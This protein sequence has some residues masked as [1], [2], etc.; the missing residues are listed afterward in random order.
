MAAMLSTVVFSVAAT[1]AP[2]G[3]LH[4]NGVENISVTRLSPSNITGLLNMNSASHPDGST[5]P[6][7]S[8]TAPAG[9]R[10]C[11]HASALLLLV[12][13]PACGL[14]TLRFICPLQVAPRA[15]MRP[16]VSGR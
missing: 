2:G 13:G 9:G 3:R 8:T 7:T 6:S 11:L 5:P 12:T 1:A 4:P 16:S 10:C 14:L 15:A